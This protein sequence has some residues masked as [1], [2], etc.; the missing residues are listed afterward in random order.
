MQKYICNLTFCFLLISIISCA[1][2][3]SKSRT[4]DYSIDNSVL[5]EIEN[6]IEPFNLKANANI[7]WT[8]FENDKIASTGNEE[9]EPAL[10]FTSFIDN[11]IAIDCLNGV[12][13]GFGFALVISSDTSILKLKVLS[14]NE[15]L[16]FRKSHNSGFQPELLVPCL[17][18]NI[19]FA[20][21][22]KFD[23]EEIVQGKID[24]ESE[25]FYELSNGKERKINFKLTAYFKSEPLPVIGNN[26]KTLKK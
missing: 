11:Q 5:K 10:A 25:P 26:Y 19:T 17:T 6:K 15:A 20:N 8:V 18:K 3:D 23:K 1:Q 24:L 7:S 13:N 14:N 22:P 12:D 2:K 4:T 21:Q 16:L 9:G